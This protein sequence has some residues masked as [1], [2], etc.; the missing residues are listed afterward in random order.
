LGVWLAMAAGGAWMFE[1]MMGR[2]PEDEDDDGDVDIAD[3][4]RW[5]AKKLALLPLSA[6]PVIRDAATFADSGMARPLPLT[7][8]LNQQIKFGKDVGEQVFGE[9]EVDPARLS[10]GA[11]RAAGAVSGIPSNQMIRTGEELVSIAIDGRE[12]QNPA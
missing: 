8:A 9:E 7:D 12:L 5:A 10:K 1:L 4:M 11:T 2:W 3:W 6:F